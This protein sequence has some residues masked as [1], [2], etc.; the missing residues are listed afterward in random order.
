MFGN[1]VTILPLT[2]AIR[3]QI[4]PRQ[5]LALVGIFSL[6][7]IVTVF[8]IIRFVLN[9]PSRGVAGP[10]WLQAWSTVEQSVSVTVACLASFRVLAIHKRRKSTSRDRM[11]SSS[12][13]SSQKARFPSIKNGFSDIRSHWSTPSTEP[14]RTESMDIQL[15]DVT[16][17]KGLAED[18]TSPNEPSSKSTP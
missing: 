5:K 18:A 3:S 1:Q 8:S 6:S 14:R 16:S 15:L 10:S 9:A 12:G 7:L 17:S 13:S 2:I 4:P 11:K